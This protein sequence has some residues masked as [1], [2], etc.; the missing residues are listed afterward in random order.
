[1]TLLLFFEV[2]AVIEGHYEKRIEFYKYVNPPLSREVEHELA[3]W[4]KKVREIMELC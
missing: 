3:A 1:M 2:K 4:K